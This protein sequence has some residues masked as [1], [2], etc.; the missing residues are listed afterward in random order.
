LLSGFIFCE[1]CHKPLTGQTPGKGHPHLKYYRHRPDVPCKAFT[2]IPAEKIERAVFAT[3]FENFVDAP[4]FER[5]IAES[6]PDVQMTKGI[7][8]HIANNTK[9]LKKIERDLHKLVALAVAGT[10]THDT[11]QGRERELLQAKAT[12]EADIKKDQLFLASLPDVADVKREAA[13]IRKMLLKQYAS[14]EHQEAMS[15]D[16]KRKLLHWLFDGHDAEGGTYGI[17]IMATRKGRNQKVDYFLYGRIMG[18]RTMFG[19][20]LNWEEDNSFINPKPALET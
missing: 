19:D 16:D 4:S 6:L 7:E 8:S 18:V 15:F 13:R 5:A 12:C 1:K 17:Y 10:L 3:I 2:Y 9:R 11:I 20:N 14:V